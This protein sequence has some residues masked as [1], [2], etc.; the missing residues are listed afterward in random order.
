M[1]ALRIRWVEN[2]FLEE[3]Y[4]YHTEWIQGSDTFEKRRYDCYK[5]GV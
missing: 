5:F 3:A 2:V 4:R 1:Y